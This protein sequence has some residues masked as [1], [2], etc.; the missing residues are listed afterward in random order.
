[1][2]YFLNM[3][4]KERRIKIG[5]IGN[6]ILGLVAVAGAVGVLTLFPG[7]ALGIAPFIKKKK[8]KQ[9]QAIQKSLDSLIQN[10]LLK[11]SFDKDGCE[12]IELTKR[13]RWEALLRA[14]SVDTRSK[15]WDSLWR[16]VVFD[17]P[18]DKQK[19]R[20]ELRRAMRLFGFRLLQKSVW[21]YP[22]PCDDFIL[23]LKER[24]GVSHDVL[25]MKVSYIENDKHLRK[26]FHI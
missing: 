26:E 16:V 2:V 13:G 23:I 17:I 18:Q 4:K 15:K 25:Y 3:V 21:V 14:P 24:L 8:Y 11:R 5:H 1:M 10:G 9:K 6:T 7:V 19:E 22:F 20:T 12:K